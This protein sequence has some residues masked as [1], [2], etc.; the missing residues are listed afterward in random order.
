MKIC[1]MCKEEKNLN[2]FYLDKRAK[3][4]LKSICKQCMRAYQRKS[5]EAR[6]EYKKQW[7]NENKEEILKLQKKYR[8]QNGEAIKKYQKEYR[9]RVK[10]GIRKSLKKYYEQNKNHIRNQQKS[11]YIRS[12]MERL[13]EFTKSKPKSNFCLNHIISTRYL[14]FNDELQIQAAFIPENMEWVSVNRNLKMDNKIDKNDEKVLK[15]KESIE[16]FMFERTGKKFNLK[17]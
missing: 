13:E 4:N 10:D 16:R 5:K 8:K 11:Y 1:K 12:I 15:A 17:L 7:Y 3:D 6:K 2:Q 14:D 9:T